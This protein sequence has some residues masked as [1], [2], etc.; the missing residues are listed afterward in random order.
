[1][2]F[3]KLY[4]LN[5]ENQNKEKNKALVLPIHLNFFDK[6]PLKDLNNFKEL[7]DGYLLIGDNY[8]DLNLSKILQYKDLIIE[9][10]DEKIPKV[11]FGIGHPSI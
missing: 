10:L 11:K 2:E 8:T 5:Y 4:N 1:L 7:I 3:L 6:I 9:K